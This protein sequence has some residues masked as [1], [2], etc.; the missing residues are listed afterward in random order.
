MKGLTLYNLM[1]LILILGFSV[2]SQGCTSTKG[3]P[4]DPQA[5]YVAAKESYDDGNYEIALT[6]LKEFTARFPYS[7]LTA[8]AEL[9]IADSHYR[10]EQFPEASAVYSEFMK[11]HPKHEEVPFAKFRMGLCQW[12]LAPESIDRDQEFTEKAVTEFKEL[13]KDY[14]TSKYIGEAK[15]NIE[16]GERRLAEA[17][18]F[19]GTFYCKQEIWHAC[20]QRSMEI[21]DEW[22][23]YKDLVKAASQRVADSFDHLADLK[24]KSLES[25]KNQFFKSMTSAEMRKKARFFQA[26]SEKINND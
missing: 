21:V 12:N 2:L 22:P 15:A 26:S 19:T 3:D 17:L 18:A 25:D 20:A 6:K 8:T 7:N 24:D 13:V 23:K 14:P 1:N 9:Q 5:A 10:L 11:L 4:N 16:K